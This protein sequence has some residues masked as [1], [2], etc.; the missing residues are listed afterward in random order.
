MHP[1]PWRISLAAVCVTAGIASGAWGCSMISGLNSL[2]E[3]ASSDDGG[4]VD[5][6]VGQEVGESGV[7]GGPGTSDCTPDP[8]FCNTHCGNATDNCGQPRACSGDCGQ[9]S[10]CDTAT[11][12]CTCAV[13]PNFCNAR[14][15]SATNNCAQPVDC[16]GCDG[17][18]TCSA[19]GACGCD[20]DPIG[21]TCGTKQC[22]SVQNN[23]K[24]TVFC[25][26]GGTS[27]CPKSGDVCKADDTCCTP[28]NGAACTGKCNT[29]ATNNCGQS[30]ACPSTCPTGQV[31]DGTSCCTPES[32]ATTCG[33]SCG[34]TKTNN[35]GQQVSCGCAGGDV[36]YGGSCCTPQ[37]GCTN[38][39]DCGFGT[40]NCGQSVSCGSCIDICP[41][42]GSCLSGFCQCSCT[43]IQSGSGGWITPQAL[44]TCQPL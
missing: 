33:T 5:G 30:V 39:H 18:L 37:P 21:T 9:N 1:K 20:P 24:Q 28:N 34:V 23:C 43:A 31:C 15:G 14:C 41:S 44:P 4:L 3:A 40:N 11:N 16:G 10:M 35:C 26:S 19:G 32:I 13:D 22:G 36:C 2:Q 12:T 7:V 17:G 27:A 42:G 25:G 38:G 8:N 29:N 6:M